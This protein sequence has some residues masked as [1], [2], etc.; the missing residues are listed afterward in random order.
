MARI[1]YQPTAR[2]RGFRPQQLSTAGI[3]RMREESNRLIQGMER[4]RRAEKEQRDKDLQAMKEDAAYTEQITREN[5][6]I[7]L[8]N[9]TNESNQK[10]ANIE[11][12]AKS[13]RHRGYFIY[14]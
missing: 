3:D 7:E 6:A 11:G 13:D 10:I 8:Q 5:N 12:K 14:N 4:R 2:S 1:Q 9:L